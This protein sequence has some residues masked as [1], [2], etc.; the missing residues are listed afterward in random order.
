M[1]IPCRHR[2][3]TGEEPAVLFDRLPLGRRFRFAAGARTATCFGADPVH[4][5]RDGAEGEGRDAMRSIET[6]RRLLPRVP[7]PRGGDLVFTGG[8][9]G[10]VAWERGVRWEGLPVPRPEPDRP[11]LWFG[12][13]DTFAI[14]RPDPREVEIVSWGLAP[15]GHFDVRL[16]LR[17][18][19]ALE[20]RLRTDAGTRAPASARGGDASPPR[21][22]RTSLDRGDHA[23]GVESILESIVRGDAYQ[24][25]LTVR[26]DVETQWSAPALFERLLEQN[27]APYSACLEVEGGAILSSSPERLLA[28]RGRSL[29]SR[30]IK[31]TAARDPDPALDRARGA[32]LLASEKDRAELLMITDLLRNDLGKVCDYG[33]VRC[34]RLREIESFP[35]VHHLTSRITGELRPELDVFDALVAVFPGGS[36]AGAPKRR[37]IELLSELEPTPRGVYT[38]TVGWIGFDRRADL[39]VAIRT[40]WLADGVFTFGAGGGIVADSSPE[41]EWDE[42]LLKARAFLIALGEGADAMMGPEERG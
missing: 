8:A 1:R 25:D 30:P 32:A 26:F 40:G 9:V 27:P 11:E 20:E 17:R 3:R 31:G 35:H 7:E 13:Y 22:Y 24:V 16:A 21:G 19:A 10:C 33:T 39:N 37:A 5:I 6:L 41:A 12:I 4:V 34:P 14:W 29:E 15:E 23:R 2:F 36:V 38:G 18:A 42:L 28:A